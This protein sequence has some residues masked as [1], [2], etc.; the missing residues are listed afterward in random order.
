MCAVDVE[1]TGLKVGF[2][3]VWQICVLPL[4]TLYKPDTSIIPFYQEI[5]INYPERIAKRALSI[6]K[7]TFA[8]KQK[9][10]LDPFTCSDLFEEWFQK[11][12]MPLNGKICPIACNWPFDRSFL[13]ELL[14]WESFNDFFHP[15][16]RDVMGAGIVFMD[17]KE[18]RGEPVPFRRF[19]L[20]ELCYQTGVTNL[21]AHDAL[22]D[23]IATAEIYRRIL[24]TGL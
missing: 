9:R 17:Q 14:G 2:H 18:F 10:A 22:Q 4:T 21:K 1:T 13:I 15:H 19:N 3:E 12:K 20:Q 8:E 23:C 5:R 11:L 6:S 7:I 24:A 16:Y